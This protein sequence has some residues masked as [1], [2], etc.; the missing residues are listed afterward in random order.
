MNLH[1]GGEEN[2]HRMLELAALPEGCLVL[3][4]G[5]GDGN[6]VMELDSIGY[7]A[8]GIDLE[9]RGDNV[10]KGDFL[11]LPFEDASFDAVL[12]QCSFFISGDQG[13]ALS[14]AFRVLKRG[15]RL[16]LADFSC[17]PLAEKAMAAG[18]EIR[19]CEDMTE[20][21]NEYYMEALWSGRIGCDGATEV[22]RKHR[23]EGKPEY[24]LLICDKR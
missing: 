13:K 2:L 3:D 24:T 18:F 9:P 15:G 11:S 5:A 22:F 10:L 21:W 17:G 12:S 14:E 1:P 4:M 7:D 8:A 16:M 20:A 19:H 23:G 6:S